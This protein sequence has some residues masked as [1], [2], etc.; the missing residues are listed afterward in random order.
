VSEWSS[1][2]MPVAY[3]FYMLRSERDGAV[4]KGVADDVTG[5]QGTATTR[6][7][8]EFAC[9][10]GPRRA[11]ARPASR[12]VRRGLTGRASRGHGNR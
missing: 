7:G 5:R 4:Y 8:A 10:A 3:Y 11:R 6:R 2:P 1:T 12:E 9:P